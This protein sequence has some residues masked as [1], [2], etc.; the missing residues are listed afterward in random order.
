MI[1]STRPKSV[2]GRA[3]RWTSSEYHRL[4]DAGFFRDQRVELIR[5]VIVESGS[6]SPAQSVATHLTAEL[7]RS[8]F[9]EGY[10]VRDKSPLCLGKGSETES[11]LA[12]VKGSPRDFV[13]HPSSVRLGESPN[14]S[15]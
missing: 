12:A 1:S 4:A 3:K 8:A 9:G 11:D 5:G 10:C 14:A 13:K 6:R 15:D 7:L 2:V